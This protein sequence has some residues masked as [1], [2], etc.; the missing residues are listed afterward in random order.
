MQDEMLPSAGLVFSVFSILLFS[1]ATLRL[2]SVQSTLT[3]RDHCSRCRLFVLRSSP[4]SASQLLGPASL[5][6]APMLQQVSG[7]WMGR[8]KS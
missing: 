2:V 4:P 6:F 5:S 8:V 1:N 7:K 3:A